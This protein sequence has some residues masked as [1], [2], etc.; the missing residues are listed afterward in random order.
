MN[1]F[2]RLCAKGVLDGF[3]GTK[4]GINTVAVRGFNTFITDAI[5][6]EEKM[7]LVASR[8]ILIALIV[9]VILIESFLMGVVL[10]IDPTS[11]K[12]FNLDNVAQIVYQVR[13]T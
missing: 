10:I 8:P 12:S 7:V 1:Q 3:N 4:S 13:K 6:Q 11:L 9:V 5:R 2:V